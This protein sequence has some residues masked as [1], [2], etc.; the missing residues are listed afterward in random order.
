MSNFTKDCE[1]DHSKPTR[2]IQASVSQYKKRALEYGDILLEKSGGGPKQPVGRVAF[3]DI[4]NDL[5]NT[6][7]NFTARVRINDKSELY[8]RFL[9]FYLRFV[10]VTGETE[11]YQKNS[12]NIRNLQT[13][14]YLN[15]QLP[16]PPL[17]E[18]QEIVTLLD[19]AFAKID[20]AKINLERNVANARELLVD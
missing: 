20:R 19:A 5:N 9:Y 14:E 7:S 8:E 16:I 10:Y 13:K 3:F 15:I 1:L 18:Q 2:N 17:E 4:E 12:T 6:F 11:K